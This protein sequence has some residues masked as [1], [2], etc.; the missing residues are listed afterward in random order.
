M[1]RKIAKVLW[2]KKLL[3]KEMLRE[4][5]NIFDR[6]SIYVLEKDEP[7]FCLDWSS[8]DELGVLIHKGHIIC[9]PKETVRWRY[10]IYDG[11]ATTK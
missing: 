1:K 2:I 3:T 4:Y 5:L 10:T 8:K 6:V 7:I 9:S 11:L